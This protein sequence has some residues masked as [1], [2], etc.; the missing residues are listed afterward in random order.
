MRPV[1]KIVALTLLVVSVVSAPALAQEPAVVDAAAMTRALEAKADT[2]SEQR[3][4]VRRVLE[5]SGVRDVASRMGLSVE[6]ATSAVATLSGSEL[7]TL[8]QHA[9]VIE[10]EAL[11]G[12]ANTVVI[13]VTTLLLILIIV[14]LL[15]Q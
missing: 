5:R 10:A 8:A 3:A 6:Q 4:L 2:E 13:S 14:I 9:G 7:E 11:A 15:V 12:G 1:K